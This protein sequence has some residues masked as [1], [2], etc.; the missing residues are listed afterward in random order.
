MIA[1][2]P[3]MRDR[4]KNAL[5]DSKHVVEARRHTW[6]V[7]DALE[8]V[9]VAITSMPGGIEEQDAIVICS[10]ELHQAQ[11]AEIEKRVAAIRRVLGPVPAQVDALFDQ[12]TP[13]QGA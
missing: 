10:D 8:A 1:L 13:P 3:Q 2:T 6:D 5:R 7:A 12:L 4:I 9:E 11:I